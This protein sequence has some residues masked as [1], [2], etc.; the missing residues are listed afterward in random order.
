MEY[1]AYMK[2]NVNYSGALIQR[3]NAISEIQTN[4]PFTLMH[5]FQITNPSRTP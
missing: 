5:M 2:Y 1:N 4:A 3:L